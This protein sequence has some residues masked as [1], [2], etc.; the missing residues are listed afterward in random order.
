MEAFDVLLASGAEHLKSEFES[1]GFRV[2][3][4]SLNS[5]GRRFF[6][7][8]DIYVRIPDV[9][10]L[11]GRRV[12]VIQSCTGSSPAEKEYWTTSDRVQELDLLLNMLRH[13]TDVEKTG[14]KEYKTREIE[15]PSRIEVVLTFQP[16]ALQDKSFRTGEAVS[17]RSATRRIAALS[18]M[19]WIPA[20]VVDS[21]YSWVQELV[22]EGTY[23]EIKVTENIIKYAAERFGFEEYIVV[24]PDEGAQERFGVPGLS[25]RR[26][27]SFTIEM[28]GELDVAGKHVIVIDDLTKSGSTLLKARKLVRFLGAKS[29]GLVVLHVMP[30]RE[31]GEILMEKLIR[32]S[33][34]QIVT[35]NS[36]YTEAFIKR[37]P[38]LVYDLVDDI[39]NAL[40]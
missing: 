22:Q 14:F 25:K 9:A 38:N 30:V 6:P 5:D 4:S 37:H 34:Q 13:P 35:S 26:I 18:D 11:S 33:E 2:F 19:M 40:R 29:V 8:S 7:N 1:R 12:V 36:V 24:A 21:H 20:P 15:P 17:C 23:R 39:L 10:E 3:S 31:E 28:H 16:F 27:D 32:K